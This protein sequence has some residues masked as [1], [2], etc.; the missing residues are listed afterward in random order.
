MKTKK[1]S[2]ME[3][4]Y[5]LCSTDQGKATWVWKA[6]AYSGINPWWQDQD[7]SLWAV[8]I[9]FC[10]LYFPPGEMFISPV[11]LWALFRTSDHESLMPWMLAG[12]FTQTEPIRA[13]Y[14]DSFNWNWCA[15][16]YFLCGPSLEWRQ[17]PE[18]QKKPQLQLLSDS[19]PEMKRQVH[20]ENKDGRQSSIPAPASI[21]Q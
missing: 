4:N 11:Q 8:G 21:L 19:E 14:E 2:I 1:D 9:W 18:F 5:F 12:W 13:G 17:V 16:S 10:L 7:A 3:Q 20:R 6:L 15:R